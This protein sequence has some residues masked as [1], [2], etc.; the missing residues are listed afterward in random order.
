M[1]TLIITDAVF[2]SREA[3]MLGR[4][5]IG[6]AD[7]GVR[8]LIA[9]P[10]GARVPE[11]LGR[12]TPPI[13]YER[14]PLP[15]GW[16]LAVRP[17][18]QTLKEAT[19]E[20]DPQIDVVHAFGGAC[21]RFATEI[22]RALGAGLALE[23]WRPG[24][25]DRVQTM[26]RLGHFTHH[27]R[28]S[29]SPAAAPAGATD[30][31]PQPAMLLLAPDRVVESAIKEADLGVPCRFAPWGVHV[32][33]EPRKVL[34]PGTVPGIVMA[35]GGRDPEHA[36]AALEA[37]ARLAEAGSPLLLFIDSQLA[38][39]AGLWKR[40]RELKILDRV[41]L[42]QDLEGRR[43]LALRAD[44]L[45]HPE[46]RGERRT[47]L[48]DAM[49]V[50]V[51]VVAASDPAADELI[52]NRTAK[53]VR[54]P[55]VDAWHDAIAHLIDDPGAARELGASAR[56]HVREHHRASTQAAAVIDAYEWLAAPYA[57]P[58]PATK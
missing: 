4:L 6:L 3:G 45:L 48:L 43:D 16:K 42:I 29:P 28:G 57:L 46:A 13:V 23:V 34:K 53:L 24:L 10:V 7:E 17:F 25:I 38:R 52:D 21:W 33:A 50:G 32:A 5:E 26:R 40:A 58:M 49:A 30:T 18:L 37:C 39:R 54:E 22:A 47:M 27:D 44:L 19:G 31:D 55:T 1:R 12:T 8:L 20:S 11:N 56:A 41:S 35:G 36:R 9:V 15:F 51:P 2:V 14:S